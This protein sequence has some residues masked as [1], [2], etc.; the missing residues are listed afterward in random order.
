[1]YTL[2]QEKLAVISIF[3]NTFHEKN[4][5][6]NNFSLWRSVVCITADLHVYP[7]SSSLG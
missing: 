3:L 7:E 4:K 2:L 5:T 1:M 6:H